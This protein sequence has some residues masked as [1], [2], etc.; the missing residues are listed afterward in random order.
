MY[1]GDLGSTAEAVERNLE[2]NFALASLW[3][4]ILLI[5]EAD[6]FLEARQ[7]ENFDRNSLVAG[8]SS[9]PRPLLQPPPN[10]PSIPPHSRILH[11][12][13]LPYHQPRRHIR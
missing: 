13:P 7:T 9:T 3:G 8:T 1:S 4:C 6:V 11:R 12:H 10:S 2:K 5:D